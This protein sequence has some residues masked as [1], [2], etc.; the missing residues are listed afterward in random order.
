MIQNIKLL[1]FQNIKRQAKRCITIISKIL[2]KDSEAGLQSFQINDE[3]QH[4]EFSIAS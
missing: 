4:V 3:R 1:D 2:E